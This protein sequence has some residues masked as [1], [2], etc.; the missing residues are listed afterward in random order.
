MQA[1]V[2][3]LEGPHLPEVKEQALCILGNI[4][5][6]EKAKYHIMA[7]EDVLKKLVDYMTHINL[8]LQ[9]AAIFCIINLVRRGESGYRERQV[10]LKEMG[11]LTILNQMLTTVTD[12]DLYEK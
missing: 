12:S 6:G 5:D 2:L 11:V 8:G 1:I 9:T 4:A 10:K 7:N 3:V